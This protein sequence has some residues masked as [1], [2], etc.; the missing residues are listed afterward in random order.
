MRP[1]SRRTGCSRDRW[2]VHRSCEIPGRVALMCRSMKA[3]T[4]ISN[5]I[6][7]QFNYCGDS[8][9][10]F[11][12]GARHFFTRR[13]SLIGAAVVP[14]LTDLPLDAFGVFRNAAA[15]RSI[16]VR[17][18]RYTGSPAQAM[19]GTAGLHDMPKGTG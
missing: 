16:I 12:A 4:D 3:G 2:F 13:T 17:A 19:H 9:A 6:D 15:T 18:A 14:I 11:K 5:R 1:H 7:D 10:K 8:V